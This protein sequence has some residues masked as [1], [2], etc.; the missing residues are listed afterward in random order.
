MPI[1]NADQAAETKAA[2]GFV[3]FWNAEPLLSLER[4]FFSFSNVVFIIFV[5]RI[6]L[7]M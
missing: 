4:T 2:V 5:L 1:N 6:T 7:Q 3:E